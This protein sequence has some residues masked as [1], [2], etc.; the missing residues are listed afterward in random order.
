MGAAPQVYLSQA[1]VPVMPAQQVVYANPFFNIPVTA[2]SSWE[3]NT[4]TSKGKEADV[5]QDGTMV[6]MIREWESDYVR[7]FCQL[8]AMNSGQKVEYQVSCGRTCIVGLGDLGKIRRAIIDLLPQLNMRLKEWSW[9]TFGHKVCSDR[10]LFETR[11]FKE[12]KK[13]DVEC[14]NVPSSSSPSS[15]TATATKA[16]A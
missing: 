13:E 10:H 8:V 15:V 9:N 7:E 6:F 16:A 14:W 12:Y 4:N 5:I 1:I 3:T 2:A 11:L